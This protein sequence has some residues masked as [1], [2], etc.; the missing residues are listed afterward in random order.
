MEPDDFYCSEL[1]EQTGICVAPGTAFGQK[2]DTYHIR[3]TT[4]V[5]MDKM[6]IVVTKFE[7]FHRRFL[8]FWK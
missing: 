8:N 6:R 7:E 2:K 4:I 5:K 3:A 1:L